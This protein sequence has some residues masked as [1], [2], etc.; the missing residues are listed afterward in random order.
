ME[1]STSSADLASN[2]RDL[3]AKVQQVREG[4]DVDNS[5]SSI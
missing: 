4:Q 5:K 3:V 2:D 1:V